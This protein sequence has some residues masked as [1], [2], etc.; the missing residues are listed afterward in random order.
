MQADSIMVTFHPI[1]DSAAIGY[2][3]VKLFG[4]RKYVDHGPITI[5]DIGESG[6]GW[7]IEKGIFDAKFVGE[8]EGEKVGSTCVESGGTIGA[9]DCFE[10]FTV[11]SSNFG[12]D[13]GINDQLGSFWD[14][15]KD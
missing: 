6:V 12:I 4:A 1:C 9:K 13:V 15:L 3:A 2:S 5:F 7:R 14:S 11:V 10:F 8:V